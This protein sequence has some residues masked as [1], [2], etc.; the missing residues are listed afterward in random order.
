MT[1]ALFLYGPRDARVAP[2]NVR[3]GR[4]GEVLV[5]VA[6]VGICGSDLHYYKDGGIGGAVVRE[7]F[8]PGHEFGGCLCDEIPALGLTRGA[9]VAV[10]PNIACGHCDWCREGYF[11]LCPNVEFFGAPPFDGA[12]TSRIW[13]P[14]SQIVKLPPALT[15]LDAVMLE[16]LGVAMHAVDLARPRLL[17]RAAVLGAGPIGLLILQALKVAGAGEVY[18]VEPQAHRREMAMRFGAA[19]VGEAVADVAGWS[20][21]KGF[22]LVVEATNNPLGFRDAVRAARIGGR[23]V[24]VGIPDGDVYTLPAAEARRRGL[25]I[26]FSRRMV[27]AYPRAIELVASGRVDVASIV[28]HCIDLA[29]TPDMLRSLAESAPGLGKV[30]IYPNGQ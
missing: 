28:T 5:E 8:V 14:T 17:E 29:A 15:P 6:A 13:V 4:P 7:P 23:V 22:S 11:N 9:L 3:E 27:D 12:M 20:E 18:V 25:K 16:P 21:G 19:A 10:D 30:L 24:L 26:R 1:E 2:F